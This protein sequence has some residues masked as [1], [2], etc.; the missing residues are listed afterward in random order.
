ML[1]SSK[2]AHHVYGCRLFSFVGVFIDLWDL[3]HISN[4]EVLVNS[5]QK[6]MKPENLY[7]KAK[8]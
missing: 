1:H 7:Y 4:E 8:S 3:L 2:E 6:C 5:A